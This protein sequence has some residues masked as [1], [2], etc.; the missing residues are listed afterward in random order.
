MNMPL[1]TW[2]A[3]QTGDDR[4]ADAVRRHTAQ[5]RD[6]ILRPDGSTFH[7]FYW[8]TATGAPVRGATEQ[9]AHDD[10]CWA[11]GQAWGI[12]GFALNHRAAS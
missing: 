7:T 4:Y 12:Y 8:D 9:G 6:H 3:E 10:S 2:A 1:L 5:L 11:R